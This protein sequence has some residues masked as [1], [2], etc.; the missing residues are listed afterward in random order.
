MGH[1]IVLPCLW[2]GYSCSCTLQHQAQQ[3]LPQESG[4]LRPGFHLYLVVFGLAPGFQCPSV[5]TN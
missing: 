5:E 3:S 1:L 2:N 4:G